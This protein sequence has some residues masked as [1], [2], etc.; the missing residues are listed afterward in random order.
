MQRENIAGAQSAAVLAAVL[1]ISLLH[2]L[3][4]PSLVH[5]HNILQY[6]Y[7]LPIAWA[8]L[9]FGWRGGL[10]AAVLA[11][12]SH[13]PD[14]AMS[15]KA[16]PDS[17]IDQATDIP[18]FCVAG[19]FTGLIAER[20]RQQRADLERT[21]QRLSEVY[22]ELQRNFEQMK[23]AERLYAVGQLSAGLA[24]EIR[25][26]LASIAGAA[27]ILQ[28]SLPAGQ[29]QAECVDIIARECQ[30]LNQLL[31][32][33]LDFARPRPPNY[34]SIDLVGL[35]DSV[36]ALAFHAIGNRPIA[37]HKDVPA[38][39]APVECDPELMK[40]VLLNLLIN[41]FQAMP[42]GGNVWIAACPQEGRVMV[43]IKDEGCGIRVEDRD[44]IFDPFFTTKENGTGLGLPVAY[45]I[46]EQHGGVLTAEANAGEGMTFSVVLPMVH[47]SAA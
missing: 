11:G 25:N 32:N 26:P 35:L 42:D 15:W 41:A 18:L 33:F 39:L 24:H 34:Q 21:T 23:R 8:A 38:G 37:L 1:S 44:K 30:R 31:T 14:I 5:W 17:A 29:R 28:R 6:L 36:I 45:Q 7:F 40:Q 13:G 27:G 4:P 19:V 20:E 47:G 2:H 22:R 46:V 10:A 43:R 12:V 16:L 3:V 9:N